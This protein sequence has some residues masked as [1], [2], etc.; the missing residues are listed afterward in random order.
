MNLILRIK[1]AFKAFVLYRASFGEVFNEDV[2][3][4][5]VS[6][7]LSK[8]FPGAEQNALLIHDIAEAVARE[9]KGLEKKTRLES[10]VDR[11]H[12]L[13]GFIVQKFS[14]VAGIASAWELELKFFSGILGA[15][16][17][18]EAKSEYIQMKEIKKLINALKIKFPKLGSNLDICRDLR[19]GLLHGNFHQL[20]V[21]VTPHLT[22]E[23]IAHMNPRMALVNLQTSSEEMSVIMAD[24][25]FS[26]EEAK[27]LGPFFWF[28]SGSNTRML[29]YVGGILSTGRINLGIMASAVG[30]CQDECTGMFDQIAVDGIPWSEQQIQKFLR[31]NKAVWGDEIVGRN[32]ISTL[33]SLFNC[34]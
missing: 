28:L 4:M 14:L 12:E 6:R 25:D 27:S 10:V 5:S 32:K 9:L 18:T 30:L 16:V 17:F 22:K 15:S 8:Y 34:G 21:L 23:Q 31:K 33:H 24:K 13:L 29:D 1:S 3:A 19:N 2:V 11:E 7:V 20:K 26:I